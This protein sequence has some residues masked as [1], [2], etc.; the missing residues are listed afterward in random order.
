MA[1]L[2]LFAFLGGVVTILSPCI[3]PILPVV[4]SGSVAGGKRRPWGI[5]TGFVIGFTFFTLFLTA[6]VNAFGVSPDRLRNVS[7]LVIFLFG[8]TLLVPYLQ[9]LLERAV[10]SFVSRVPRAQGEGFRSGILIGLSLGLIWTPCVGP[11]LASVISLALTGQVNGSAF[12]ITLAYALGTAV[13]MLAIMYGGRQLLARVPGLMRNTG[14]I[15]KIFGV[16][17]LL[18]A[19]AIYF[20]YDRKF[21]TFILDAFPQYGIGLTAFESAGVVTDQLN[22]MDVSAAP[23]DAGGVFA[24]ELIPGGE[25]LNSAPLTLKELRGSKVVLL[26]FMTYSCINCIRT[27]P[28]LKDWWQKY[29]DDGLVIIGIHTPE[30][31]F[32]K[33]PDNVRQAL[34]DFGLEFPVMQDNDYATWEAYN[35][36]Y[37]PREYLIDIHGRV[38]YDHVGEGNYDETE[39]QIQ[40]AL[41]ERALSLGQSVRLSVPQGVAPPEEYVSVSQ[42]PE[43]YFGSARNTNLGNGKPGVFGRQIFEAPSDIRANILYLVGSWDIADEFAQT[44]VQGN[45]IIFRYRAKD[46]YFV[47]GARL[48][49]KLVVRQ[50]GQAV[51][52]ARGAD[53]LDD[54]MCVVK[55]ERLYHLISNSAPGEHTLEIEIDAVGLQAFTFTFG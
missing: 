6:L 42:S 51:G 16:L 33:N 50:D 41:K 34:A 45:K 12:F 15:Q 35:N 37:W 14:R 36:R 10:S 46:V 54:A 3:L 27:F 38:V 13:P 47:A 24:P 22:K 32:E 29:Q 31:E 7:V 26:D 25:W 30:F 11:I 4:L 1:I 18:T 49:V 8:L 55:E 21:Q 28:Y 43:T 9:G 52:E 39:R 17:M 19:I 5:V 53:V 44:A 48:P 40:E 23:D 20:N 2:L